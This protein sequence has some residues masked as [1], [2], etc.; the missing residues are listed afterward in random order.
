MNLPVALVEELEVT[1]MI[2]VRGGVNEEPPANNASGV[3][4]GANNENGRCSGTNNS[5]GICSGVNNG[6]GKCNSGINNSDGRCLIILP[7]PNPG[8]T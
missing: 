1:E 5:T 8:L 3:C 6:K 7:D 2:A 4:S